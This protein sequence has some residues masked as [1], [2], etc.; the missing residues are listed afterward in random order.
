[1]S[2]EFCLLPLVTDAVDPE[3]ECVFSSTVEHVSEEAD[4]S[5]L[6]WA[7]L[8]WTTPPCSGDGLLGDGLLGDGLRDGSMLTDFANFDGPTGW[9]MPG[10]SA[11]QH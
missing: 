9:S 3:Y 4:E 7:G 5:V 2:S 11:S 10:R 8:G 1:L 6:V